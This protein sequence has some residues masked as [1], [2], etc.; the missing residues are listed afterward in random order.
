DDGVIASCL[1]D[2]GRE[3]RQ[4]AIGLRSRITWQSNNTDSGVGSLL[5]KLLL[6]C[7]VD[8]AYLGRNV[9]VARLQRLHRLVEVAVLG[10][11]ERREPH[12]Q[13]EAQQNDPR[14]SRHACSFPK[15][16]SWIRN[17]RV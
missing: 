7:V 14:G 9:D 1:R 2:F 17:G 6:S 13:T 15:R 4:V 11:A 12:S 5:G 10:I 3:L 8:V 16:L